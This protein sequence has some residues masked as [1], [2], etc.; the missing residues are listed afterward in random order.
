MEEDRISELGDAIL[1]RILCSI[2]IKEA[3]QTSIL[4]K[5]WKKLWTSMPHL[6]F[7]SMAIQS[8]VHID[9]KPF[10]SQIF[11]R[12]FTHFVIQFLSCRDHA[13]SIHKFHLSGSQLVDT[14]PISIYYFPEESFS[15]FPNLEKLSLHHCRLSS[16][17]IFSS[18]LR[19]LEFYFKDRYGEEKAVMKQISTPML[20]SLR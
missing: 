20:T 13:S 16:L 15:G 8:G 17:I 1:L 14:D 2:N 18:K 19:I 10:D 6:N 7:R 5:R 4:S 3:V 11:M 12:S 9:G